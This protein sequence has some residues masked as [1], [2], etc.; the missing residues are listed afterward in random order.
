MRT[1]AA[2]DNGG[3]RP[4]GGRAF[5]RDPF[6]RRWGEHPAP[7]GP[8]ADE[9][10]EELVAAVTYGERPPEELGGPFVV[11]ATETEYGDTVHQ[12]DAPRG[13]RSALPKSRGSRRWFEAL[14]RR[15]A[16][17]WD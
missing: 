10:G 15:M 13:E 16:R 3:A 11:T 6:A 2:N 9:L 4:E 1:T 8:L 17:E 14:L 7:G 12:V 5:L